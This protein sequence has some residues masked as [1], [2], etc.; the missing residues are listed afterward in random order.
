LAPNTAAGH[1][2]ADAVQQPRVC[3]LLPLRAM[4]MH[5]AVSEHVAS[6][7]A[8]EASRSHLDSFQ[9]VVVGTQEQPPTGPPRHEARPAAAAMKYSLP[10][11]TVKLRPL[12]NDVLEIRPF[13]PRPQLHI[14]SCNE[15]LSTA[16]VHSATAPRCLERQPQRSA[17]L[18]LSEV[19]YCES[20]VMKT[21]LNCHERARMSAAAATGSIASI[22]DIS[23]ARGGRQQRP[24]AAELWKAPWGVYLSVLRGFGLGEAPQATF[25]WGSRR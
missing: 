21:R 22:F 8:F 10:F 1:N 23:M 12:Q 3:V 15:H 13:Q 17:M 20:A 2:R 14:A 11:C 4:H 9:E 6:R 7:A 24:T 19:P 25:V 5:H 16:T 18:S